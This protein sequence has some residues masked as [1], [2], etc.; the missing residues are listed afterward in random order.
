MA[1]KKTF[2][3][4]GGPSSMFNVFCSGSGRYEGAERDI[5][6][7]HIAGR[8]GDLLTDGGCWRNVIIT[9]PCYLAHSFATDFDD[10]RSWLSR[11]MDDYYTLTDDYDANHYRLARVVGPIEPEVLV[12]GKA[13]TITVMFDCKPQRFRTDPDITLTTSGT[14]VNPTDFHSK[15]LL[16]VTGSGTITIE[17]QEIQVASSGYSEIVIDCDTM[18][19]FAQSTGTVGAI[20]N[21]NNYV[22]L[23]IKNVVLKPGDNQVTLSGVSQL[24]IVPRFFDM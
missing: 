7:E 8:N 1:I 21:A 22:S 3:L 9:Y 24:R 2:T 12:R 15:P 11:H 6:T 5:E 17:N 16:Y 18:D 19:A 4:A 10:F 23:P 20:E 13:G 14:V